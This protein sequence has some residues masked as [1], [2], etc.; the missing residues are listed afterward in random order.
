MKP[1]EPGCASDEYFAWRHYRFFLDLG[2]ERAIFQLSTQR[3]PIPCDDGLFVQMMCYC[4]TNSAGD[5]LI[6]AD[7]ATNI[8]GPKTGEGA[9]VHEIC[10]PFSQIT[11]L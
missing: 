2:F 4:A 11:P 1:D 6:D 3:I 5:S 9:V 7:G 8:V 10:L